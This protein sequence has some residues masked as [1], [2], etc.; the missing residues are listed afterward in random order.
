MSVLAPLYLLGLAAISL[1]LV[2]HLI[3]RSPRGEMPFSSSMFLTPSPPRLTRRSRLDQLLLLLLRGLALALLA[4][5]FAR[6]F[7]RQAARLTFN[8]VGEERIAV[9]VDTS[10]SMRRGR[11][12]QQAVAAVDK[13][14]ARCRPQ[15]QL[16]V[17]AVDDALRPVATF[18]YLSQVEPAR[19]RAT[20]NSRLKSF[21]PTWSGTHLGQALAD[22][23]VATADVREDREAAARAPR[24]VVLVSDMQS[25]SRLAALGQ[26]DWPQDVRL[27]LIPVGP[28]D[29]TNAGLD[30]LADGP[31][32][33]T[34]EGE[35]ADRLRI[36]VTNSADSQRDEFRIQWADG[37]G[38]L[39]GSPLEVY[40]PAGE[41]RVTRV[42][43]PPAT[44]E[45]PRLVLAGDAH[46]FDNTLYFLPTRPDELAVHYIGNDAASDP[47]GMRYYFE[48]A[49]ES[50]PSRSVHVTSGTP[51]DAAL[52]MDGAEPQ[53]VV[54]TAT[55]AGDQTATLRK[56]VADGGSLLYV[57]TGPVDGD[58]LAQLLDA[59]ELTVTEG[60]VD[61]YTMLGEVAFEHPLF[62]LMAGPQFNDFTQIRFWK[63]RRLDAPALPEA[64]VIARF[65]N[66]DPAMLQQR[67]GSG[68]VLVLAT[69]WHPTDGQL[70][71][72][73]KFLL[74]L[75]SIVEGDLAAQSFG[76][77]YTV[78]DR[79]PLP[80]GVTLT[81]N[82]V[83]TKPSGDT[84]LLP[85]DTDAF[86]D[87]DQPGVYSLAT[88]DGPVQFVVHVDPRETDTL[89]LATEAFEQ[90][91]CRLT[92]NKNAAREAERMEQMRDVELERRQKIW[93]WLVA[94]A[95]V[96]L[97]I[98]TWLAGW[99]TR[100]SG[101]ALAP[102]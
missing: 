89:P 21:S 37:E 92:D 101:A 66:G 83:V 14:V 17:F 44:I 74:M 18:D 80:T 60:E 90:L 23:V 102:A 8:N 54:V 50:D 35:A 67:I 64:H 81:E 2:F 94:A 79:V 71:R 77:G 93:K 98:E 96:V 57:V 7:L 56:Y 72:S 82:P 16:A 49:L 40:T 58:V 97:I 95:L 1:P 12:W 99:F 73:W 59:D 100:I 70:A 4:C 9:L 87:T 75:S 20:V 65:E 85:R 25:G 63:Y 43:L 27:E 19:R 53:L 13:V 39:V 69:G 33:A 30:Q 51:E 24:R 34:A 61:G 31:A 5:A 86:T 62:A 6:P 45:Q 38:A 26:Q 55:P 3:R 84:S 11:L 42:P 28:V 22:A 41:S 47:E 91:G 52:P 15:D 36:R 88:V 78:N 32:S 29:P 68:K 76:T 46:D 10:A 48:S